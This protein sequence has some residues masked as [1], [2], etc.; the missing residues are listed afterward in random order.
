[1]KKKTALSKAKSHIVAAITYLRMPKQDEDMNNI[2]ELANE[3]ED[4]V[5]QYFDEVEE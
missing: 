1:M 5:S 4:Y 3:L 2:L